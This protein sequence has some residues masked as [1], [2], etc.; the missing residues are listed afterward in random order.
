MK[1]HICNPQE[2]TIPSA[3][4]HSRVK[5]WR[6]RTYWTILFLIAG[7]LLSTS[8]AMARKAPPGGKLFRREDVSWLDQE[9][10]RQLRACRVTAEDGTILYTPDGH[11]PYKALWT[12]D[13]SF[14]VENAGDLIPQ[15]QIRDAI[16][17]LLKGQREDGCVPDHVQP[18]GQVFYVAGNSGAPMED[19]PTDNSQF[20]VKLV[21]DYI[22]ISGDPKFFNIVST[23]LDRA[24][25]FTPRSAGGLVHIPPGRRQSAFGYT[26]RIAE[27][28]DLL[29][30]SLL[31]WEACRLIAHLHEKAGRLEKSAEYRYRAKLIERNLDTLFTDEAG[32]YF[33]ASADCR[34]IDIWGSAY[35]VYLNFPTSHLER[36]RQS[37]LTQL[38]RYSWKG[39]IRH[40][41]K[42]EYWQGFLT[43]VRKDTFQNGAYWGMASGW[44]IAALAPVDPAKA[45]ALFS[46]LIKYYRKNGIPQCAGPG[47]FETPDFVLSAVNVR[48]V[49]RR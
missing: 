41:L 20:M 34:Q 40:L 38:L 26:N 12:R 14:M 46:E 42:G 27:S 11:S 24:M 10:I 9:C 1:D 23:Q 16:L 6:D 7:L 18:N 39:Q 15:S 19:A 17:Y 45:S 28:G 21:A 43:D 44:I 2:K 33:A 25:N 3:P 35:S 29:F 49:A 22:R 48:A 36:I 8:V 13:F 47:Y 32:L 4:V 31:Y 30:P 37:L 5:K